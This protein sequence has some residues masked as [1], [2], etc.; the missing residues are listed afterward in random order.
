MDSPLVL[1]R[2]QDEHTREGG[3]DAYD[4][5]LATTPEETQLIILETAETPAAMKA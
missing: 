4:R 5:I 1:H 2:E 3:K